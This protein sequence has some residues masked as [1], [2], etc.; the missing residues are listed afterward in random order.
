MKSSSCKS[1]D[2]TGTFIFKSI[3]QLIHVTMTRLK[4]HLSI[5]CLISHDD[6]EDEDEDDDGRTAQAAPQQRSA[7]VSPGRT[8]CEFADAKLPPFSA[9]IVSSCTR[10]V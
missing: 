7:R 4:H 2:L 6:D 9:S 10:P 1:L 3:Y 5:C 8:A